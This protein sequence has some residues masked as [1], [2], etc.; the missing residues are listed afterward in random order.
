M[1]IKKILAY[2]FHSL[3]DLIYPKKNLSLEQLNIFL[4]VGV[5]NAAYQIND[6]KLLEEHKKDIWKIIEQDGKPKCFEILEQYSFGICKE[7]STKS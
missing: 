7:L 1:N 6:L 3:G 4:N 5:Y 2:L